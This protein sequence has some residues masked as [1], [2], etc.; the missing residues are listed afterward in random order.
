MI[1]FCWCC[2]EQSRTWVFEEW[3][4]CRHVN[5]DRHEDNDG[6]VGYH[7]HSPWNWAIISVFSIGII[8]LVSHMDHNIGHQILMVWW[9]WWW[10]RYGHLFSLHISQSFLGSNIPYIELIISIYI[11]ELFFLGTRF[12]QENKTIT[13]S[14]LCTCSIAD[15]HHQSMFLLIILREI[16]NDES[17]SSTWNLV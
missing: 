13:I 11:Y 2:K 17:W 14:I 9:W 8:I 1:L 4:I 16:N 12:P 7:H 3:K 15:K 10:Y 6:L 5:R